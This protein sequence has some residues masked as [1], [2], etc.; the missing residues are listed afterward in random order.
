MDDNHIHMDVLTIIKPPSIPP[1]ISMVKKH[2]D[3]IHPSWVSH[4]RKHRRKNRISTCCINGVFDKIYIICIYIY[5]LYVSIYIYRIHIIYIYL[6]HIMYIYIYIVFIYRWY[7][8]TWYIYMC[9]CPLQ[10]FTARV[11][12][13]FAFR[14]LRQVTKSWLLR[15]ALG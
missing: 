1:W 14:P 11:R 5:I 13:P 3:I 8:Y 12:L 9:H 2:R 7:R 10:D 4:R 6:V 15:L